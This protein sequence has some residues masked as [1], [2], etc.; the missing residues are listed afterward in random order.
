[1]KPI[2]IAEQKQIELDILKNFADFCDEH[3]LRYFLAYG[4]LIGAVR[5]KGFIPW[6]DD[7]DVWMPRE[8]YNKLIN[9]YNQGNNAPYK[10]IA[11][12]TRNSYHSFV[13]IVNE[14][15]VKLEAGVNYKNGFIGIDID[16]FPLDGQPENEDEYV[17]WYNKIQKYYRAYPYL[18]LPNDGKLKRIIGLPIIRLLSGGKKHLLD[19]AK[20][21]HDKYP[22]DECEFIGSIECCYDYI[23]IRYKKEWFRDYVLAD[24]EGV[25]FR[26]PVDYDK[27]LT[28]TYGDYMTPPPET[29][30][31]THHQNNTFW[32]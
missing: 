3:N 19:K 12:Y 31:V 26:I 11:P 7:I 1:M 20:R 17:K 27:I 5:H 30:Q 4:T 6:D 22:Y 29:E 13:K 25:K 23:E 14:K 32:L 8:D 18:N 21:L 28:Q 10:L 2:D 15:T 24:F 9:I 16:V